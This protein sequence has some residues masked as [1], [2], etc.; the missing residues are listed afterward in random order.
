MK[1]RSLVL[2]SCFALSSFAFVGLTSAADPSAEA[3]LHLRG[4]D[5]LWSKSAGAKDLDKTVSFYADDAMVLAP[6]MPIATSKDAI[7]KIWKDL[8]DS[9]GA[10]VS[11][12]SSK[13]EVAKSL[14]L[15]CVTGTYEFGMKDASGKPINEQGKYL[16]VFKKQADGKWK[17]IADCWN[18]DL[19]AP[20]P[21][22]KK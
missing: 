4:L 3:E 16:E 17:C 8:F 5:A 9:P 22:E 14:D 12:K 7:R 2:L 18:S 10:S 20:P 1:K 19:P 6:N 15:A 11:W 21:A 13:V